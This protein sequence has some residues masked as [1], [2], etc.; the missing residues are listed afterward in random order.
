LSRVKAKQNEF[1]AL[2]LW[3]LGL[4]FFIENIQCTVRDFIAPDERISEVDLLR[5]DK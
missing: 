2:I 5:A 3:I 4:E 1:G